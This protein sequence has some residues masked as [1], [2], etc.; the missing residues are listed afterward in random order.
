MNLDIDNP[1]WEDR[2]RFILSKGHSVP[3]L[4]AILIDLGILKL[5]ETDILR[6]VNSKIP[7][8]PRMDLTPGID[9]STGSLGMGLSAGCG[10]ALSSKLDGKKNRI[11]A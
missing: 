8:H 2:D 1:N 5:E 11:F 4:Y 3:L 7:G 10:M 9:M 6:K